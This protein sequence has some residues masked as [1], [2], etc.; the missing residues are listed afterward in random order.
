MSGALVSG[1]L[2]GTGSSAPVL[3]KQGTVRI[4]GTFSAT[5]QVE[6]DVIGNGTWAPALDSA[7]AAVDLTVPGVMKIDNG[8]PCNTRVTCSA[9]TSGTIAYALKH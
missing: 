9:Y 2:T 4:S 1:N 5:I 8:A 3:M 7:G 6:V